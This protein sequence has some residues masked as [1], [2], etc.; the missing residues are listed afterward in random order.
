MI[1]KVNFRET[2]K[3]FFVFLN[4]AD[5]DYVWLHG[6]NNETL[7]DIDIALSRK[8]YN[9]IRTILSQFCNKN[10]FTI[11]QRL[12]HEVGA[13][14]YILQRLNSKSEIEYLVLDFCMDFKRD[15]R[16][17]IP[18]D[19][20]LEDR[21]YHNFFFRCNNSIEA[22]YIFYKRTLKGEWLNHHYLD[23]KE[24]FIDSINSHIIRSY[25]EP[26]IGFSEYRAFKKFVDSTNL[27]GLNNYTLG[28]RKKILRKTFL[29]DPL[30][31]IKFYFKDFNRIFNRIFNPTGLFI[32]FIGPDGA[33]KS[34]LIEKTVNMIS[35]VFRKIEYFHW[36]YNFSKKKIDRVVIKNPHSMKPR[37]YII[38]MFKIIFYSI[39]YLL[40][41][42]IFVLT[43]KIRS[44]LIVFDRYYYDFFIDKKR[45]RL[46]TSDKFLRFFLHFI[47]KPDLIFSLQG[48][49]QLIYNRKKEIPVSEIKSQI[50]KS[51]KL[52]SIYP[53][54][55]IEVNVNN[56]IDETVN[57]LII[58]ISTYLS[59]K[60]DL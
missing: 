4:D 45:Y 33:G 2:I 56:T 16:V 32:V 55:F 48:D 60:N 8:H 52:K 50:E 20:L 21:E 25:I 17:L 14:Y 34:T 31:V 29:K 27:K 22:T 54:K 51:K 42:V 6:Y 49:E 41:Y 47:P 15:G 40:G 43:G 11:L 13:D 3:D 18:I 9:K 36:I 23:F 12:R 10:K 7:G 57:S 44:T 30:M 59:N 24:L 53:E 37:T 26:V 19:K 58:N 39:K 38:S 46:K 28:L 35:P 1:K 5:V